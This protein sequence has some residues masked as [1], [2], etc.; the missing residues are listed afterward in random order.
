M[1]EIYLALAAMQFLWLVGLTFK[2]W[3]SKP[4]E[5][6]TRAAQAASEA[7]ERIKGR[8]DVLEE[9]IKH[10]PSSDELIQLEGTVKA[11]QATQ[12]QM[13]E[14]V[15]VVRNTVARIEDHLRRNSKD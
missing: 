1:T 9:R 7:A 8:V 6:A 12:T 13:T 15:N 14:S 10:M 3:A 2:T 4:G 11:I 5:D